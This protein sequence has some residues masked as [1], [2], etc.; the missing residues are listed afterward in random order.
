MSNFRA[1]QGEV[2]GV[3]LAGLAA[4]LE[5]CRLTLSSIS[6]HHAFADA[7]TYTHARTHDTRTQTQTHEFLDSDMCTCTCTSIV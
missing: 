3:V 4:E 7:R 1:N 5:C 6:C 2:T